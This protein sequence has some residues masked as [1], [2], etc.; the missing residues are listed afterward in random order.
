MAG[1]LIDITGPSGPIIS[2]IPYDASV[3]GAV[4]GRGWSHSRSRNPTLLALRGSLPPQP[5]DM[6][7]TGEDDDLIWT[8]SLN[9]PPEQFSSSKLWQ[10]LYP[11]P[12]TIVSKEWTT[13]AYFIDPNHPVAYF[14]S[15]SR[16]VQAYCKAS[17]PSCHLSY[18]ERKEL[19]TP[20]K[21]FKTSCST[22]QRYLPPTSRKAP[23]H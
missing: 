3:I 6:S 19:K 11:D 1:P 15:N 21:C 8:N 12:E 18:L 20:H 22:C 10:S 7:L 2:G 4:N 5:P 14:R 13:T 23:C 17:I 9:G 16:K